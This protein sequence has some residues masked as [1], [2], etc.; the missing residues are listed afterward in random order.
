MR[1]TDAMLA[2]V[3]FGFCGIK[4][5]RHVLLCIFNAY[6]KIFLLTDVT[7]S[8]IFPS[9]PRRLRIHLTWRMVARSW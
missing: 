1:E 9:F 8:T 3:H 5:N 7:Q 4:L 6:S 2:Q